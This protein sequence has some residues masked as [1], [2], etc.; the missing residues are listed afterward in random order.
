MTYQLHIVDGI[1]EGH[2]LCW[3]NFTTNR[4]WNITVLLQ[5]FRFRLLLSFDGLLLEHFLDQR[6]VGRYRC[7]ILCQFLH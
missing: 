2:L 3:E 7:K 1:L 6:D 5:T 4:D